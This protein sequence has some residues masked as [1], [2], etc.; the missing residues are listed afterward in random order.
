MKIKILKPIPVQQQYRPTVGKVYEV[1]ENEPKK[2]LAHIDVDGTKVG[3][4]TD[5]K[6]GECEIIKED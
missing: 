4:Y 6:A 1:L 3:V 5:P 2:H